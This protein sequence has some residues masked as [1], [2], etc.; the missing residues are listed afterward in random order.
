MKNSSQYIIN[1]MKDKQGIQMG[2]SSIRILH[3][4]IIRKLSFQRLIQ[5]HQRM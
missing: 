2:S 4:I 3:R 5:L 1:I